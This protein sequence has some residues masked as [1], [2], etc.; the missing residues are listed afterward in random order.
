MAQQINLFNPALRPKREWVT[1]ANM[2]MAMSAIAVVMLLYG[3]VLVRDGTQAQSRADAAAAGLKGLRD[4]LVTEAAVLKRG[5]DKAL[6][7]EIAR[8][9]AALKVREQIIGRFQGV[10][11][12]NTEGFSR[13]LEA[14]ARQRTPGVWLTGMS[15]SGASGDIFIRGRA[16]SADLLPAFVIALNREEVLRGKAV[17]ELQLEERTEARQPQRDV[18]RPADAAGARTPQAPVNIRFIEFSL[19]T[20]ASAKS[21]G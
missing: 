18:A 4:Q 20:R 5:P 1:A 21:D 15:L 14:F 7:D 16:Q 19:G 10:G 17:R 3:A 9:E 6:G 8:L 11:I 2:L 13:Y 12:G